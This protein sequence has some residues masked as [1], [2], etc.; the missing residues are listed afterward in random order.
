MAV[1]F[2]SEGCKDH[3]KEGEEQRKKMSN[4]KNTLK[5]QEELQGSM[6]ELQGEIM[7]CNSKIYIYIYIYITRL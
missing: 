6:R 2:I 3:D 5:P 7:F 1:E 4:M